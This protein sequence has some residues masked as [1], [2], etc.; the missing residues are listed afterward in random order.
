MPHSYP[1]SNSSLA[2]ILHPRRV[3]IQRSVLLWGYRNSQGTNVISVLILGKGQL[4]LL[5]SVCFHVRLGLLSYHDKAAT[6]FHAFILI[7]C[8][9]CIYK[10]PNFRILYRICNLTLKKRK[11]FSRQCLSWNLERSGLFSFARH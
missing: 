10:T 1:P 2:D 5:A 6:N 7:I 4:V 9:F 3:E 11:L 8:G